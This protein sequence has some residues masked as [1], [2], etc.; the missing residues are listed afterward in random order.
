MELARTRYEVRVG[1]LLSQ[2]VV[3]AF[4]LPLRRIAVPRN[5]VYRLS[6]PADRDLGEVLHRL[7]ESD[8]EVL[9]IRRCL[10][11][12]RR[13]PDRAQE[14]PET[15]SSDVG[16]TDATGDGVV[17]PFRSGSRRPGGSPQAN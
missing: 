17:L 9:E 11:G 8:V 1:T 2:A 7:T 4:R 13:T 5:S 12:P 10:E 14:R 16:A 6:V 15:S 3:A